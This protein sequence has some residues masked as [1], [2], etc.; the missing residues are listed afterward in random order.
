MDL[1][2]SADWNLIFE[3]TLT[4]DLENVSIP[5]SFTSNIIAVYIL[6]STSKPT[7]FTGGWVNQLVPTGLIDSSPT[8]N[9]YSQRLLL[10][11]N[12]LIFPESL[13]SYNLQFSFPYYFPNA[14][15]SVWEYIGATND[16]PSG[17]L[18]KIVSDVATIAQQVNNLITVVNAIRLLVGG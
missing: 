11:K 16:S 17:E 1:S 7:W 10:G 5:T 4:S 2:S 9:I 6:T 12:I 13:A 8:W 3:Q 15:L 18:V 14:F